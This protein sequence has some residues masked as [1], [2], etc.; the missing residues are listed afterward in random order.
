MNELPNKK[1]GIIYA[2]PP[3]SYQNRGT[4]AAAAKHYDTMTIE[5]I[6]KMP[7]NVAGGGIASE[8]CTLFMWATFPMLKEALEVIEAWGFTYKTV[9]FCWVKQNRGGAGLFMGLGNW[10]RSNAE[11]CLLATKGRPERIGRAVRS[12]VL[13]PI[14]RHSKKP[15]EVRDRIVELMGDLPR[16]ELFARETTPGWDAWGNEVEET[17]QKGA[18]HGQHH[19]TDPAREL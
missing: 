15:D 13:S 11:I 5:D 19:E 10:T 3:W 6:K 16:I 2:D 12:T 8:D 1:Y 7:V 9:A 14:E 18:E 17:S 4:R